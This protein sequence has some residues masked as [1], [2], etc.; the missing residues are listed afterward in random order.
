VS[1]LTWTDAYDLGQPVK[2][3]YQGNWARAQVISLRTR[4]VMALL[5][6]SGGQQTTNI[7]DPR[8]IQPCPPP[9]AK[10]PES[11]STG[12]ASIDF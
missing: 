7:H 10:S 11:M 8:N 6:R 5:T 4:S 12:Q 2:V 9:K 1:V 3:R